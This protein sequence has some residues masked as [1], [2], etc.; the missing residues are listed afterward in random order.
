MDQNRARAGCKE[1]I[2]GCMSGCVGKREQKGVRDCRGGL[3]G[4]S[5]YGIIEHNGLS[6]CCVLDTQ[7]PTN[8]NDSPLCSIDQKSRFLVA[9][10][11]SPLQGTPRDQDSA[12]EVD[13]PRSSSVPM[14]VAGAPSESHVDVWSRGE[15]KRRMLSQCAFGRV[16]GAL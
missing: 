16:L 2:G 1:K 14:R 10:R 13:R 7:D 11:W 9:S 3:I 5:V 8:Q 4:V 15:T 6:F 12:S